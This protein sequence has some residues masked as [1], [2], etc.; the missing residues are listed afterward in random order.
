[1][2]CRI[3]YL[4]STGIHARE[5]TALKALSSALPQEWLLYAS[6]QYLPPRENS[7]DIDA[8]VVMDDRVLLLEVKDWNGVLTCNGDNWL[9]DGQPSFL[10]P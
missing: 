10:Q 3:R 1:V 9:L 8:M 5:A 4:N 7:L 2:G 6:F